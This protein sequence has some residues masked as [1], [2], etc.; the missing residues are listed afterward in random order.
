LP[1]SER[2]T[3]PLMNDGEQASSGC[4]PAGVLIVDDY[5]PNR[6]ALAALLA[7]LA[8]VTEAESGARA[9]E[10]IARQEHAVIVLD[11][12][13]PGMNGVEVARRIRAGA[14]NPQVPIIFLTAMDSDTSQILDGYAAGAVDYLNRPFEPLILKSKVS[15]FVE[16]YQRREQAKRQAAEHA[17]LESERAAAERA[18]RQKDRFVAALSHELRTPLASIL[19]W[20]DMLLHKAV[21]SEMAQKGLETIDLCARYETRLV[22]NVLEMSRLVTGAM[23]LDRTMIDFGELTRE[24]VREVA[25]L[26]DERGVRIACAAE[27]GRWSGLGDRAR[28]R[29]VLFNLLENAIKFTPQGG[30]AEITVAG[31]RVGVEIRISD[32]GVGF[33]RSRAPKL[34]ERFEQGD[35]SPTRTQGGL[36]VGLA[37]AKALIELHGGAISADSE[38]IGRGATFTITIPHAAPG[39]AAA[40]PTL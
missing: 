30:R 9:L 37:L 32:T 17:R 18:S 2:L 20:T 3:R 6:T 26:A 8:A 25:G 29:H 34:F 16:L 14:H 13:M 1:A 4:A 12:Q 11:I 33:E 27:S 19:L 31:G 7:P 38:G 23:I 10:A 5:A 35:S 15:I 28:L 21:S 40:T 22:D 24:A 36:G 39:A